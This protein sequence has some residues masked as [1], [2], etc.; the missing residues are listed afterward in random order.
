MN[1]R[2]RNVGGVMLAGEARCSKESLSHCH[3][4]YHNSDILVDWPEI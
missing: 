4:V 2:V 3:L 1:E